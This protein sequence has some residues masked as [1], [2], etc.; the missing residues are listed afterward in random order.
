MSTIFEYVLFNVIESVLLSSLKNT[1]NRIRLK[2]MAAKATFSKIY[3]YFFE[4]A[5]YIFDD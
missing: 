3:I 1:A 2:K 4:A 5:D